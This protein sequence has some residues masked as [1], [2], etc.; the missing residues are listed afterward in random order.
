MLTSEIVFNEKT[1]QKR[2]VLAQISSKLA[3]T[4]AHPS[5]IFS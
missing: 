1:T 5:L 4:F 3:V 2:P